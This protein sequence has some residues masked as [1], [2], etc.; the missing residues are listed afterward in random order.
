MLDG[1]AGVRG[2]ADLRR[3]CYGIIILW[4]N[5]KGTSSV[6]KKNSREGSKETKI[7]FSVRNN[8]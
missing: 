5:R 8:W 1:G 7:P 3:E 4:S 2:G 6:S